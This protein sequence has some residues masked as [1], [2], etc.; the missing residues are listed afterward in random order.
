MSQVDSVVGIGAQLTEQ[1]GYAVIHHLLPGSP[2][3]L[4]GQI[5]PGDRILAVAQGDNAFVDARNL[6]LGE[7]VQAIRGAPSTPV[8]LQILPA[9][10]PPDSPPATVT[11]LRAQIKFKRRG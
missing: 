3:E 7:L 4:S 6:S 11:L 2:A 1:G 5:H 8:Q 9:D 10:A